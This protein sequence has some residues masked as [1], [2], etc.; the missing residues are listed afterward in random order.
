MTRPQAVVWDI[1]NVLLGWNPEALYD[2]RIGQAA[3]ERFFAEVPIHAANIE[4]DRGAPF[5]ATLDALAAE[6]P[7]FAAEIEIWR[8]DWL[9][10]LGP[11]I[12][13]SV[14]LLH[15]LRA[16][17]VPCLALTN[18]GDT[19]FEMAREVHGFLNAFDRAYVSA[20][21]GLIKPDPAIYAA[22]EADCG[23]PPGG[24]L[25]ADDK[26]ENIAAATAR[27]WQ[28]HHF[29]GPEGWAARLVEAGLLT[30]SEAAP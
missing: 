4:M 6:H 15:R 13:H 11:V 26:A 22:V 27:G 17:G 18:F 8:T 12:D 21:M 28:G 3:R 25:F 20:R 24:L 23:L 1:G 2:A 16:K 19:T 9:A 5:H 14:A 29:T 30:D 7:G 10:T